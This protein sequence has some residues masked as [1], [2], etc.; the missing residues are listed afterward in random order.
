M[1]T[2]KK[3]DLALIDMKTYY[4]TPVI[5]RCNYGTEINETTTE[6]DVTS[7]EAYS[8]MCMRIP[9]I[10]KITFQIRERKMN[11]SIDLLGKWLTICKK[12][13]GSQHTP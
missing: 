6:Q 2:K 1:L 13:L 12:K 5:R 9:Y 8:L 7:S 10:I 3:G 4:T 11:Y